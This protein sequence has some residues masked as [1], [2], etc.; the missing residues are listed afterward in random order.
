VLPHASR[1]Y[2]WQRV[3]RRLPLRSRKLPNR[4][5]HRL[6]RSPWVTSLRISRSPAPTAS[7]T[8]SRVIAGAR[9]C[10][11][12][13]FPRRSPKGERPS[14]TH[15]V[16]VGIRSGASTSRTLLSVSTPLRRTRHSRSRSV[17]TTRF[18]AIRHGPWPLP[19][20]WSIP[21][22]RLRRA[23]RSISGGTAGSLTSTSTS[24]RLPTGRPSPPSS[25]SSVCRGVGDEPH[26]IAVD[27]PNQTRY[28]RRR[29]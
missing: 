16:R 5:L 27:S 6:A 17:S 20:A 23:G 28:R 12:R 8:V 25:P 9:T 13:G 7:S 18:S 4:S 15:S 22:N 21:I 14:A 26:A 2:V 11:W 29:W 3:S 24:V 10:C 1:R 19:T